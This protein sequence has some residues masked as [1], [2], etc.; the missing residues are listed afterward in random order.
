MS[1]KIQHQT[2]DATVSPFLDLTAGTLYLRIPV[3]WT[4]PR[5]TKTFLF[6][7]AYRPTLSW[8]LRP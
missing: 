7:Q 4:N 2:M 6:H 8:L 1:L 3:T 5:L